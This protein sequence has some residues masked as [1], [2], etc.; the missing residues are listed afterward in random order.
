[1]GSRRQTNWSKLI[2]FGLILK[3][4]GKREPETGDQ[5][6]A[7]EL[8]A[9]LQHLNLRRRRVNVNVQSPT[10]SDQPPLAGSRRLVS[11][12]SLR[13]FLIVPC[14]TPMPNRAHV[15]LTRELLERK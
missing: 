15:G 8:L 12:S 3:E 10:S 5:I 11:G 14:T 6:A 13:T 4:S 1:V 9:E 2:I 7:V